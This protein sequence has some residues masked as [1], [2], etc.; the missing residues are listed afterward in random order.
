MKNVAIFTCEEALALE[1][2][3]G[4]TFK[5]DQGCSLAFSNGSF[6]DQDGHLQRLFL[7]LDVE[8]IETTEN[9]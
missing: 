3:K 2:I 4:R 9:S 1:L 6:E 7:W 8:L 5:D